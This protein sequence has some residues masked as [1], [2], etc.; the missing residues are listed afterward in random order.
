MC[1]DVFLY[2]LCGEIGLWLIVVG[3]EGVDESP[4][5][6]TILHTEINVVTLSQLET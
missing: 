3:I 5:I 1:E 4:Q 6:N 2:L